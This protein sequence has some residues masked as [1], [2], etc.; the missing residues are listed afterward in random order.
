MP[1]VRV[2][3]DG[4]LV[5]MRWTAGD[6]WRVSSVWSPWDG[7]KRDFEVSDWTELVPNEEVL[8]AR[9]RSA[10]LEALVRE[11]PDTEVPVIEVSVLRQV[12]GLEDVR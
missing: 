2:S 3:P 4:E 10:Q 12:L 9:F 8:E 7:S 11:H 1:E 5:A 6:F